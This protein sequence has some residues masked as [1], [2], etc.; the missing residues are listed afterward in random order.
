LPDTRAQAALATGLGEGVQLEVLDNLPSASL[1][2]S[3]VVRVAHRALEL[4]DA[5]IRVVVVQGT[6]TIED[7]AYA[8]SLMLGR[9]AR[10]VVTG[11]MHPSGH[12]AFDGP[13][14]LSDSL[15]VVRNDSYSQD[16]VLVCLAGR[17]L[18]A[19]EVLKVRTAGSPAFGAP[20]GPL[21][22]VGGERLLAAGEVLE[23][24]VPRAAL[25]P[26]EVVRVVFDDDGE[27]LRRLPRDTA[28]VVLEALGGG[29]VPASLV[30]SIAA[31]ARRMPVALAT[32]IRPG[33][34]LSNSY[35]YPGSETDLYRR[36]VIPTGSLGADKARTF[37]RLALAVGWPVARIASH[38]AQQPGRETP[39]GRVMLDL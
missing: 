6:D 4:A 15:R 1:G 19:S 33:R 13:D 37:I 9:R 18:R 3:H 11:A 38:F 16:G 28:G 35:A 22:H 20:D 27:G 23:L 36:G 29:H 21:A 8:L 39:P 10:V 26:V 7:V 5:G 14:N 2:Y 34:V 24:G 12:P 32:R 25:P 30:E 17:V 31:L